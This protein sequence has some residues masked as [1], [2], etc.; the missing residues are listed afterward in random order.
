MSIVTRLRK[1]VSQY[2]DAPNWG[3]PTIYPAPPSL[4]DIKAALAALES[5]P[6]PT[7]ERVQQFRQHYPTGC[8]PQPQGDY[9][10]Y[11][12]CG[13]QFSGDTRGAAYD[14][15]GAH[16]AD[17][18]DTTPSREEEGSVD[19]EAVLEEAARIA[20]AMP[21]YMQPRDAAKAIRALKTSTPETQ[22]NAREIRRIVEMAD[23]KGDFVTGD[24]GYVVYWPTGATGGA[25]AAWTLRVLADELDARNAAWD[26]Q[27][28]SALDARELGNG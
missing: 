22:A 18:T 6:A 10:G 3:G 15:W 12:G 16:V 26:A 7:E 17:A 23:S 21:G 20:D 11:C 1:Y 25:F 2:E 27:V 4:D 28:R 13:V 19:R 8:W 24:D 5:R 9:V 14:A